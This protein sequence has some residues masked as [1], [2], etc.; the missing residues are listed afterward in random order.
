MRLFLARTVRLHGG[1]SLADQ[2]DCDRQFLRVAELRQEQS[3]GLSDQGRLGLEGRL[4]AD[5]V[6]CCP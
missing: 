2:L 5:D 3:K 6:E 4:A 1:I